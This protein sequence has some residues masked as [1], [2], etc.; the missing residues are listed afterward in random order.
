MT[1]GYT[2]YIQPGYEMCTKHIE[3]DVVVCDVD[4]V[5]QDNATGFIDIQPTQIR[6]PVDLGFAQSIAYFESERRRISNEGNQ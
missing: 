2:L 1:N 3:D 6:I 4:L 5:I